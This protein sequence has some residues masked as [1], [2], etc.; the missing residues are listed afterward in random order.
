VASSRRFAAFLAERDGDGAGEQVVELGISL[1]IAA[2]ERDETGRPRWRTDDEEEVL[3]VGG[4]WDRV[5]RRWVGDVGQVAVI[6]ITRGGAQEKGARWLAGWFRAHVGGDWTTHQRWDDKARKMV[7]SVWSV[8]LSGGR[9]SGKSHLACAALAIFATLYPESIVWAVSPTQDETAEL[10]KALRKMLPAAWYRYRGAGSGKVSTFTLLHGGQ[11][12]LLSGFKPRGL[13]RG[14]V[15]LVLYNEG[16]NMTKAGYV[17]LRAAIADSGG[18]V[19]IAANPPDA[20]IGQWIEDH[21]EGIG[22]GKIDGIHFEFNPEDNPWIEMDALHSMAAEVDEITYDRDVLGLFRPIGDLVM[23]AWNDRESKRSVPI[24]FVDVTQ[25]VTLHHLGRA[26]PWVVGMDFQQTPHMAA[27][28]LKFFRDP[29]DPTNDLLTW[30]VGEVVAPNTDEDGLVTALECADR[31]TPVGYQ[32]GAG[33]EPDECAV[34]MD[35]SGWFQDGEHTRGKTSDIKLKARRWRWLYKPQ[36]DSDRN[37]DIIER[38]KAGNAR[39]RTADKRRHMFVTPQ[40]VEV[41][42]ALKYWENR[43]GVPYRRSNYA[44]VCDATTYPIYRFFG[45][46]K[47]KKKPT[48]T[49]VNPATRA[50]M[51]RGI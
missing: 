34:I 41:A 13:R 29:A 35:A 48:F 20:P 19:L 5:Q 38:V 26:F 32:D 11:I 16:Q 42:R 45:R 7:R 22:A 43:N 4:R 39:L 28:I 50:D 6:R 15:D 30:V 18:L 33:Y 40:C 12:L 51:M 2:V 49:P 25:E 3:R 9:R 44:H 46:P 10:E 27:V 23:H 24:G 36:K 37:P 14:R 1:R 8:L 31:W 21:Q 47:V 17:Q